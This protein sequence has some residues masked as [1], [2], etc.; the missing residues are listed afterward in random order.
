MAVDDHVAEV[1]GRKLRRRW[2][3]SDELELLPDAL[4]SGETVLTLAEANRGLRAGLL[5][6]TDKRLLWLFKMRQERRLEIAY[7]DIEDVLVRKKFFD[8]AL[9]IRTGNE[10]ISFTDLAPKERAAELK[11]VVRDRLA[12]RTSPASG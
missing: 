9:E 5:A 8:T 1:A 3:V 11:A 12:S 2:V 7:D 10:T 6:A 4:E